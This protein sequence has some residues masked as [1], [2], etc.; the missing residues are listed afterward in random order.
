MKHTRWLANLLVITIF[1]LI[2]IVAIIV[3][4]YQGD[5]GL[6]LADMRLRAEGL[7]LTFVRMFAPLSSVLA[8][9][10]WVAL[11]IAVGMMV[12]E[13]K[14]ALTPGHHG[15]TS[16]VSITATLCTAFLVLYALDDGHDVLLLATGALA[17]AIATRTTAMGAPTFPTRA[18]VG[19]VATAGL[20]GLA[21][22]LSLGRM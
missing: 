7:G 2:A 13:V 1:P 22:A 17:S 19:L 9:C 14:M 3:T 20:I 18:I 4:T 15:R 11:P 12:H 10:V 6:F 21:L 16:L 8:F 5:L